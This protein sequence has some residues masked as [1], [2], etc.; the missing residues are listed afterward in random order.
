M[1]LPYQIQIKSNGFWIPLGHYKTEQ[2]AVDAASKAQ[3]FYKTIARIHSPST[4]NA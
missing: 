1:Q 4:K 2:E 3:D